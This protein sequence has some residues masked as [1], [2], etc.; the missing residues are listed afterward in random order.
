[1]HW[2]PI[3]PAA[4]V[5]LLITIGDYKLANTAR[6]AASQFQQRCHVELGSIWFEGHWG[7]QYYMQQWNAKPLD[8]TQP[9]IASGDVLIVP[10]NNAN[11]WSPSP[12]LL[13]P[14]PGQVNFPQF[15]VTTMNWEIHA[16]F[17]ASNWGP[18]PWV[19]ALA[20]PEHYLIFRIK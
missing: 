10:I 17:Y 13:M 19:V 15:P 11:I 4:L 16:G 6:I 12:A 18:L 14:S 9:T 5:S 3:L 1:M 20:P 8:R 7:F 2:W